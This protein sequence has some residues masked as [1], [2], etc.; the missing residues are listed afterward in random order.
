MDRQRDWEE[1][2]EEGE[3]DRIK[4]NDRQMTRYTDI[5]INQQQRNQIVTYSRQMIERKTDQ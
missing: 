2:V 5:S 4:E 1:W 3:T